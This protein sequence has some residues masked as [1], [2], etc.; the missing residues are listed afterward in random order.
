MPRVKTT[1]RRFHEVKLKEFPSRYDGFEFE[2]LETG[3]F[4]VVTAHLGLEPEP[5][6]AEREE[7]ERDEEKARE[8]YV[9]AVA[10][11]RKRDVSDPR[12]GAP[13]LLSANVHERRV[14]AQGD[15]SQEVC[16][17]IQLHARDDFSGEGEPYAVPKG[18]AHAVAPR[19][20]HG[21]RQYE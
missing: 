4:P 18:A 21:E 12:V 2:A 7:G 20:H 13:E 15:E 5:V 10:V 1:R 17:E 6:D 11:V 9:P 16:D 3:V 19:V 8:K 14:A